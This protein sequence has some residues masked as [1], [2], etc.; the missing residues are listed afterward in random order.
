MLTCFSC[1]ILLLMTFFFVYL[2]NIITI[3]FYCILLIISERIFLSSLWDLSWICCLSDKFLEELL[4]WDHFKIIYIFM[5]RISGPSRRHKF[6]LQIHARAGSWFQFLRDGVHFP[7]SFPQHLGNSKSP[8]RKHG[9]SFWSTLTLTVY[10]T[11]GF[12][13]VK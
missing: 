9:T 1:W 5:L 3:T 7:P 8:W 11:S 12:K 13:F 4:V 2:V 10:V 6:E